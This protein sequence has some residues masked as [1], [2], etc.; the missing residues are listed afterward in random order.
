MNAPLI[1]AG[2]LALLGAGFHGIGGEKLVIG[3][4][5]PAGL[6]KAV[7]TMVH[8]TWHLTT[9]GFFAVGAALVLSGTVLDGDTAR[10]MSLL[11]AATA[12]GFALVTVTMAAASG[13]FPRSLTWHPAPGVLTATAVLAWLGTL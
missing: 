9:V 10:G 8:V 5:A 6:P 11:A 13:R 2:S 1:V 7:Q 3:K 4:L 12:T